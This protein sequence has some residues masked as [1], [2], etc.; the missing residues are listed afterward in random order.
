MHMT[1]ISCMP[2]LHNVVANQSLADSPFYYLYQLK[3][4]CAALTIKQFD[5]FPNLFGAYLLTP[6]R[7]SLL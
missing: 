2:K 7:L 3:S 6:S 5:N 4:L 1:T